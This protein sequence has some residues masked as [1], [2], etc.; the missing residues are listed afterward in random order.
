VFAEL[1]RL[2]KP[3]VPGVARAGK[4]GSITGVFTVLVDGDDH[5]EPISDA[6]RA[7]LDGHIVMERRIAE[8]GRYPAINVLK[9]ISRLMPMCGTAAEN[10]VLARA[11]ALLSAYADMEELIR[12]G[13]YKAGS[14]AEL[15]EAI[16]L[17]P[18]LE[19]FLAQDRDERFASAQSFSLL[20]SVLES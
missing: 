1:P 9:S 13:A 8:R 3:A 7:I 12:I 4:T 2:L 14:D 16:R 6:V 5:N 10:A 20:E 15:D 11:R 18:G 17:R 19:S